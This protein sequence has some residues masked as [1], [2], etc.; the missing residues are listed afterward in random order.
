MCQIFVDAKTDSVKI[1]EFGFVGS[2]VSDIQPSVYMSLER[3]EGRC[4]DYMKDDVYAVA[5]ILCEL[6]TRAKPFPY[7]DT[8]TL[9]AKVAKGTRP[10]LKRK[11]SKGQSL[12]PPSSLAQL[13]SEC[14]A[15]DPDARPCVSDAAT[16]FLHG[17]LSLLDQDTASPPI[18]DSAA[19]GS[20]GG[21]RGGGGRNGVS[22]GSSGG[23]GGKGEMLIARVNKV[24]HRKPMTG[25]AA[26]EEEVGQVNV[27][28]FLDSSKG[29][30]YL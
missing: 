12:S 27:L 8:K 23:G 9:M 28:Q 17:Q 19:A 20:S 11:T 29:H 25:G 4:T 6:W 2:E 22:S 16:V 5:M 14:W 10:E 26:E 30:A 24:V 3:F 15:S 13:I 7:W 1:C 21:G 18:Q